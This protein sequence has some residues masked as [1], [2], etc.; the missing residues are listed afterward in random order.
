M[1]QDVW[2][3]VNDHTI[4]VIQVIKIFLYNSVYSCHISLISSASVRSLPFLSFIVP[5]FPW[6]VPLVSSIFLKRPLAFLILSFASINNAE[7]EVKLVW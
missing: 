3:Q 7:K 4:V 6:N 5:I 1:L 2:L